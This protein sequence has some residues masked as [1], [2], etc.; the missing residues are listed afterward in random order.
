[1]SFKKTLMRLEV[2]L[3]SARPSESGNDA[4]EPIV[5][6][7]RPAELENAATPDQPIEEPDESIQSLLEKPINVVA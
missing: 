3:S 4:S 6:K 7:F 1:M 5:G 2:I